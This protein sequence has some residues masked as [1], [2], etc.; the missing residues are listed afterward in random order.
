MDFKERIVELKLDIL[1]SI[2]EFYPDSKYECLCIGIDEYISLFVDKKGNAKQRE[3]VGIDLN[4]NRIHFCY[5]IHKED[6]DYYYEDIFNYDI[7]CDM[8]NYIYENIKMIKN[9]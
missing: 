3:I 7:S 2:K 9:A 6:P 1:K 4:N 5:N 8:L